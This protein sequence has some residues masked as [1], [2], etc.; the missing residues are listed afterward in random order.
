MSNSK[1]D[2]TV[3]GNPQ[4]VIKV[5]SSQTTSQKK[6]KKSQSHPSQQTGAKGH[7]QARAIFILKPNFKKLAG[8][9]RKKYLNYVLQQNRNANDFFCQVH[10]MLS[11]NIISFFTPDTSNKT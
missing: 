7:L 8:N 2:Q 11:L 4:E 6:T 5:T 3:T 1:S 9:Y 10:F